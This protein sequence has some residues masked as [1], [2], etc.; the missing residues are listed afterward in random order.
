MSIIINDNFQTNAPKHIDAKYMTFISGNCVPWPSSAAAVSGINVSYRFQYL[1]VLCIMN[2]DP[3]EYW[4][5]T[6]TADGNIEPKSKESYT[7]NG[8]GTITLMNN[9]FYNTIVILPTNNTT[10]L[11]IG[12]TV[13][14]NDIEN[15]TNINA[16]DSYTLNFPFYTAIPTTIYF[17]NIST[18]TKVL[19]YKTF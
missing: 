11:Q 12:T 3:V 4:W 18:G 9:Y 7:L 2:G 8:T 16:G 5:R 6:G 10:N 1:T 19:L 17:T 14:G 13:G 15:G